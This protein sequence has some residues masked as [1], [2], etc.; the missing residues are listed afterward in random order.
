VLPHL[1]HLDKLA[2]MGAFAL[3][4]LLIAWGLFKAFPGWT[5]PRVLLLTLLLT[6]TY[7]ALDELHQRH[8]PR[9]MPDPLDLVADGLGAAGVVALLYWRRRRAEGPPRPGG[10]TRPGGPPP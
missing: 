3:L 7:G 9:R 2:H 4:A 1:P 10:P 6:V 5:T 8:V